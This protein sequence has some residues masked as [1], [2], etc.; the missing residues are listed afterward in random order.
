[1]LTGTRVGDRLFRPGWTS[2]DKRLQYDTY[3][4]TALLRQGAN[5]IGATL[6]DGWYRGRLGFEGKRNTYGTRLGLLAQ[7]IVHYADGR[8]EMVGTDA[9]WKSATGPILMSD[10]YDGETYDARLEKRGW[11]RAGYD[12]ASW[13][14]V[15]LIDGV[16]ATLVAPAGPPV[17]RMQ[18]LKPARLLR[19]PAGET[20]FDLGQNMVGWVRLKVSGPAGTIVR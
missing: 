11:S 9:R 6:G 7:L 17:R 2:Y 5:A 8:T 13:R 3:D 12:D 14:G 15:Q 18:E 1:E 20:V 16:V 19:T 10:I 4:V